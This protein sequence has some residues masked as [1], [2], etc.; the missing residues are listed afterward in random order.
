M[1]E[2]SE[3]VDRDSLQAWLEAL[4]SETEAEKADYRRIAVT[5]AVRAA[6]RVMPLWWQAVAQN[7]QLQRKGLTPLFTLRCL[8]ISSVSTVRP[9]GDISS[10]ASSAFAAADPVGGAA[11]LV[12]GLVPAH[13]VDAAAAAARS[14]DTA[15]ARRS[16]AA[17]TAAA[18]RSAAAASTAAARSAADAI[19]PVLR[20]DCEALVGGGK[21]ASQPLWPDEG[22][23][24]QTWQDVRNH[25]A[26]SGQTGIWAFWTDWYD[27]I[28][29]PKG[30]EPNWDMLEEIALIPPD[31]WDAGP[32]V[33]LP[34]INAIWERYKNQLPFDLDTELERQPRATK[35]EIQRVQ[36]AVVE[37]RQLIPPTIDA[38]QQFIVL[39]IER[40]QQNNFLNAE[41][42]DLCRKQ[43][44]TYVTMS[45]ALTRISALVPEEGGPSDADAEELVSLGKLYLEK[46]KALPRDKADEVI[47]KVWSTGGNV[48]DLGL[49]AGSTALLFQMGIPVQHG[50]IVASLAFARKNVAQMISAA[51][52]Y[53][54]TSAG[55]S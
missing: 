39:E 50:V 49:V 28:L 11:F 31:T 8:L 34:V 55:G 46:L 25:L 52:D 2:I 9:T 42:P 4:P 5:I 54:K 20:A 37:N 16:A 43:I 12:A 53:L 10:A 27:C 36:T 23:L 48:V 21:M 24:R 45:E 47:E 35:T 3:I 18:A 17:D 22:P 41:Q 7:L 29:D 32:D 26:Q 15:A 1:V 51:N 30:Q 33:A 6:L 19:W 40:W 38:L 14:A 13:A 44:A